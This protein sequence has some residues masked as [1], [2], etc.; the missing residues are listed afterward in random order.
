MVLQDQSQRMAAEQEVRRLAF[1]DALTGLPNRRLLQDRLQQSMRQSVRDG[2]HS[3]LLFLDLDNFKAINDSMGHDWGDHMLS[4]VA[5]RLSGCVRA[6]DTVARL[7]GD[8]FVVV[9]QGLDGAPER[10]A[11]MAEV[12]AHKIITALGQPYPLGGRTLYSTP[13]IGIAL[14]QGAQQ[15]V[16]ELLKRA[17]LA[18]YQ[19][20]AQGRNTLCFFDPAMQAAA[21]ARSALEGD[22]RQGLAR[23]EFLLHY[24]PVVD[25]SGHLLGAE[26]LVRWQHPQRGMVSPADFIPL[27]EQTGLIL[28]LGRQ[29]L[30]LA[31]R[32]LA[33]WAT[34]PAT[35]AWTLAVNVSAQE[36]RQPD[37]VEQ[38]LAALRDA[39]ANPR[40]LKLELTESLLLHDVE[41]SILKMQALRTLGVGDRKSVV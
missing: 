6:S 12:V 22:I 33:Q 3:A 19:A 4:Q 39:A 38:V 18:M 7:G 31:C 10:A 26:A 28:P 24:Q 1:Y 30:A 29:V 40:L 15:P 25:A 35:A 11:A 34:A 27:A 13:S 32:Q 21:S 8:E 17:D 36:F 5:M 23:N 14:F 2:K 37:F 41:D 16:Q 20:K 9:L